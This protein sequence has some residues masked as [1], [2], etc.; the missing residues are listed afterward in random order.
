MSELDICALDSDQLSTNIDSEDT[1]GNTFV[2]DQVVEPSGPLSG[3]SPAAET[4]TDNDST[5]PYDVNK[6]EMN[7]AAQRF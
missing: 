4:Q 2:P 1:Y 7:F 5:S 3:V 6:G